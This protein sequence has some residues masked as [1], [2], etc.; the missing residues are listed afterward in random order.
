VDENT[1]QVAGGGVA[2]HAVDVDAPL[3]ARI[4]ERFSGRAPAAPA[5]PW[6]IS[7]SPEIHRI[8]CYSKSLKYKKENV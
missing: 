4:E 3:E 6:R 2:T 8:M 1:G 5:V 7:D